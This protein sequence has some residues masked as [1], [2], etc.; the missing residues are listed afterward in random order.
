MAPKV[1][2]SKA[3]VLAA[4]VLLQ[5]GLPQVVVH[6]EVEH[7]VVEHQEVVHQGK[8]NPQLHLLKDQDL[9]LKEE[10]LEILDLLHPKDNLLGDHLLEDHLQ[11]DKQ[12]EQLEDRHQ[13]ME[14]Q[15]QPQ[16]NHLDN[17]I[18]NLQALKLVQVRVNKDPHHPMVAQAN[19]HKQVD[20][21]LDLTQ[22][23]QEQD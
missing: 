7:Q 16:H 14:Q 21:D 10:I 2:I 22:G 9:A 3:V 6:Q 4:Q 18:H 8:D 13:E 20:L 23:D 12:Q 17:Q 5:V 11:V 1:R 15:D 19:S